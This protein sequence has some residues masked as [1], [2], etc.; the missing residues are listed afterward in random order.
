M[1]AVTLSQ[2]SSPAL[3]GL[4]ADGLLEQLAAGSVVAMARCGGLL[5]HVCVQHKG[6][7]E[8]M[9][10]PDGSAG[11]PLAYGS[12]TSVD[13]AAE[14][15]AAAMTAFL[16]GGVGSAAGLEGQRV[17]MGPVDVAFRRV[18]LVEPAGVAGLALRRLVVDF[19]LTVVARTAD[20]HATVEAVATH[21]P[22]LVLVA[23]NA[24]PA[25]QWHTLMRGLGALGPV[26]VAVVSRPGSTAVPRGAHGTLPA[27][28][29][30]QQLHHALVTAWNR[31]VRAQTGLY[32]SA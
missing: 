4:L 23:R 31:H 6:P 10:E 13:A 15:A 11:R 19:G 3:A 25:P 30:P 12:A 20:A 14:A 24:V 27:G 21:A 7:A 1:R 2:A 9:V 16:H 8:W 32:G 22:D 17:L 26:C 29:T 18:V 28:A 5:T